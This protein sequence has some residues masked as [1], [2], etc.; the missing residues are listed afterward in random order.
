[1]R[2]LALEDDRGD[3][4]AFKRC[5][6]KA[7]GG[8][9]YELHFI[10]DPT[11]QEL[12]ELIEGYDI[13]FI[14]QNLNDVTGLEIIEHVSEKETFTPMILLTGSQGK[15]IDQA[16]LNAGAS[17]YLRKEEISPEVIGR[18]IRYSIVQMA[19]RQR[20]S[21][22][23]FADPLTGLR[24]RAFFERQ[25]QKRQQESLEMGRKHVLALLDLND[26]KLIN[27]RWG[28]LS[29]DMALREIAVRLRS[30]FRSEDVVAR[31]GGD[32]FG[33]IVEKSSQL[34]DKDVFEKLRSIFEQPLDLG[35]S[36][37][38]CQ[39]SI[40]LTEFGDDSSSGTTTQIL[41]R[42]DQM[43][44]RDKRKSRLLSS[45]YCKGM[46]SLTLN[47]VLDALSSAVENN[48]LEIYFQPK[49][50]SFGKVLSGCE[51]L[52]RWNN[53]EFGLPP[54]SFIP[55][56]EQDGSIVKVGSWALR[57]VCEHIAKWRDLGYLV[58]PVAVN[59]SPSQILFGNFFE[60]LKQALHDFSIPGHL[61]ELEL[62]E[63]AF[64]ERSKISTS[65]IDKVNRLGCPWVIDD[66]GVG[67]SS[68]GRLADWPVQKV[69]IDRF[70]L[71]RL[72]SEKRIEHICNAI[73]SLSR[74][75]GI[76]LVVEGVSDSRQVAN[77]NI[78]SAD[79]LQGYFF[80]EPLNS[81]KFER[82]LFCFKPTQIVSSQNDTRVRIHN[83]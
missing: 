60:I 64:L 54:E 45:D 73:I 42:A 38:I 78:D 80:S 24:N 39:G 36:E 27:D 1:M 62:T 18:C 7:F 44:Y 23:A 14:D 46:S 69:K 76:G 59:V 8:K 16:A 71:S 72:P 67:Y 11:L 3:Q 4:I 40:G 81:E 61:I 31:I 22:L 56:S 50:K 25:L 6:S 29:G 83:Q 35:T 65:T 19:Q 43:L 52:L 15:D 2:I 55:M 75:L 20:L 47:R 57:R 12:P 37:C 5:V 49:F 9:D 34:S 48:E 58:P 68:L 82:L 21:N 33:V 79:E 74:A 63:T 53:K 51:A 41:S 10:A 77:L 28:H 13:C 30:N 70:F 66:F 26:F 32:E 17:D